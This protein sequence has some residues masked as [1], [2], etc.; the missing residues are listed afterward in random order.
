M[1]R[2]SLTK[3]VFAS[4]VLI[5][6]AVSAFI[7]GT[8]FTRESPPFSLRARTQLPLRDNC[9]S[10]IVPRDRAADGCMML[11]HNEDMYNYCAHHYFVTP[12]AKHSPGEFVTTLLGAK[13]PQVPETYAYTGTTIFDIAYLNCGI[14]SGINEN[15]VAVVNNMS[16]RRDPE[17][18]ADQQ[19]RIIC[20][21]F[22][23]FAL[24]RA[25][26]ASEAVD[27]IGSL[28]SQCKLGADTGTMF[29]VVDT[30]EGWWVEVTQE[31]QWVAQRMKSGTATFRANIFR[32]GEVNFNS[33]N[34][35]YSADLVS[36]A[37]A[38]GWYDN[39]GP[40]NFMD[41]YAD[42]SKVNDPYN[43]LRE[44]RMQDFLN[45]GAAPTEIDPRLIM[46][47]LRDHYEGYQG[48]KYDQTK[49]HAQGSPHNTDYR[50]LC[51]ID[52]EVSVVMQPRDKI[53]GEPVP[54]DI[55]AICWRA[56]A[57]PC[58]SIY[59]PWYLGS[60]EVPAEYQRGVSQ[61][62]RKSAYWAARNLSKLVDIRYRADVIDEV[63][64]V[65]MEFEGREFASQ[66]EVEQTALRLYNKSP[67]D[68]R[69]YLSI[70]TSG[71]ARKATAKINTL[72]KFAQEH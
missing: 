29:G 65:Q 44:S 55:G 15:L 42:P 59:T 17:E 11:A 20:T 23:Q 38:K 69:A 16:Y 27:V 56:M 36:Y 30:N 7:T 46:S 22:T 41:V 5:L 10:I 71:L 26:T 45:G 49:N 61:F 57:T 8:H 34:F 60:Q 19:G 31:G 68:A 24:E 2:K 32:I 14:T 53:S 43:T 13:V 64:R 9:S 63:K 12:H 48:G 25:K 58:T 67:G 37:V 39:Q 4:A 62:T 51:R 35:K 47:L 70:Y 40:F 28:A 18:S 72:A 50:T 21:E 52:T 3:S 66:A 6:L 33:P 1:T 54:A